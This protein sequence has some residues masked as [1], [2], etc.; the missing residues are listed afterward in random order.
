MAVTKMEKVTLIS[1]KKN[2]EQILQAV[3]GMHAVEIRDLFQESEN[4]EWVEKYFPETA[5]IDK[6]SKVAVLTSELS[7]IRTAIQFIEHHGE[8]GQK[9]RH[10]KRRELSLQELERDYS[11]EAFQRKLNEV[12]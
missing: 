12:L 8:K 7:E 9:K 6:E 11:E 2:Q 4:N 10:L 3:Q 1:D 5:T